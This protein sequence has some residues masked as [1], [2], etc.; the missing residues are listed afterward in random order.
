MLSKIS[1]VPLLAAIL[2]FAT[3]AAPSAAAQP[4]DA[5]ALL[6]PA[7]VTAAIGVTVGAGT[8][9]TPEFKKTCTWKLA[10]GTPIVT[11]LIQ[12]A[13]GFEGGKIWGAKAPITPVS[14]VG[15]DAYYL[16]VGTAVGL[17][18]KKSG[19]SYKVTLYGRQYSM[20]HK[21]AIEKTLALQVASRL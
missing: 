1:L 2:I 17:I 14:G 19:I 10:D 6:T 7:Q 3:A 16:A 13:S 5:C 20:E 9:I 21:Q 4:D 15:E 12:A 11:L 8:Y 18:V